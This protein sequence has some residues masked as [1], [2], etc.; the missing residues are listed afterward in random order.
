MTIFLHIGLNKAG[1]SSLQAFCNS[2]RALLRDLGLE[3][4]DAGLHGAAHFGLSKQLIG[5]PS[6]QQVA[7]SEGLDSLVRHALDAGRNVLISSE[8]FFLAGDEQ[9]GKVRKY[10]HSL[11]PE[12][13][14]II[15][16]RRHDHW[17]PSLFNQALKTTTKH[18]PWHTD[19][20]DFTLHLLGNQ[21]T[22]TRF[23]VILD[24]WAKHF[25]APN[26]IVRPFEVA[27]FRLNDFVWD[28]LGLIDASLPVSLIKEGI[29]PSRANASIP[30][31]V[32]RLIESVKGSDIS[33]D[34]KRKVSSLLVRER[35]ATGR[36]K[37]VKR[38]WDGRE[39]SLPPWLR[40][41]IVRMFADDYRYVA[42]EYLGAKDGVLFRE[43]V[44]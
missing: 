37:S 31:H 29:A 21:E 43:P 8:F 11:S 23:S 34:T 44:A 5:K 41:S 35:D 7:G 28:A 1:S 12:C 14:I 25:G 9:V 42:K 39:F 36:P 17:I 19:I 32:L 18:S 10:L 27:Q 33:V 2:E 24:R 38:A 26:L 16:L 40:K 4:P 6:A 13:K 20:R 30:E 22:E 15:Y 3:Y